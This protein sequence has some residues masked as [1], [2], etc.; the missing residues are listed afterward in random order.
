MSN[1]ALIIESP[2]PADA[3]VI[4]L[5][6]LGADRYDF[7][8]VVKALELPADHRVRFIFPQAPTR[9]VTING[10]YPMPCWFDILAVTPQRVMNMAQ[11]DESVA[12]VRGLIDEQLTA[13]IAAERIILAGFSQG[14]AVIMHT[15]LESRLP[16]GGIMALSTYG[17]TLEQLLS[18]HQGPTLNAFFAHGL[19]DDILQPEMG[20]KAH[21]LLQQAGH[22][23]QWHA[24][25]MAH[26]V[27]PQE[28]G[29][30]RTWLAGRLA[31]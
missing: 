18:D 14:G 23:T 4:W 25:P 24:Y 26:E 5:H 2:Q 27:C 8:P 17:P 15:A 7:V 10:G 9:P 11:L 30:I 1:Q 29:D 12:M 19:Y 3:C 31:F 16:L 21:D 20:R 22:T 6:G 28:I 13:G